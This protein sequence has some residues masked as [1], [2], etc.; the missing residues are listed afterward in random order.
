[1]LVVLER[2][3]DPIRPMFDVV[4]CVGVRA[5]IEA[6]VLDAW[7]GRDD[8][9]KCVNVYFRRVGGG[10]ECSVTDGQ[11]VFGVFR[12]FYSKP[13]AIPFFVDRSVGR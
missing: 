2:F 1:M 13:F 11:N 5:R 6:K 4:L 9:D 12:Q 3:V 10:R 8:F 7:L